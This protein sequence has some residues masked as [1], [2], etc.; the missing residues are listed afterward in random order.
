MR[1]FVLPEGVFRLSS[2]PGPPEPGAS[3]REGPG[4]VSPAFPFGLGEADLHEVCEAAYGDHAAAAGFVLACARPRKGAVL[5]VCERMLA[6][7]RGRLFEAGIGAFC[8]SPPSLI[9]VGAAT[10]P[11]TL[12]VVE[13]AARSGAVSLVVAEARDADFTATRRLRLASLNAGT[14]V[15][16]LMPHA[17]EGAS[18]AAARWRVAPRASRAN[19]FD[20]RAPGALRW[21]ATLE[22]SRRAPQFSGKTFDIEIDDETLSLNLAP[23]LAADP[24]APPAEDL[25]D[26]RRAG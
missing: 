7:E 6:R 18:A 21:R 19:A 26:A 5:W 10:T 17:R 3:S 2:D 16:L 1:D 23:G 13:E 20:A 8:A 14:P 25:A 11:E 12:W 22:R 15:I 24:V 9:H 4:Q